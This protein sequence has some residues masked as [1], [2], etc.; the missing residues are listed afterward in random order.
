MPR[1][2][3]FV[4]PFP[5]ETTMRFARALPRLRDVRV[6]AIMQ[7]PPKGDDVQVFDDVV[8]VTDALSARDLIDATQVLASRHGAPH[9]VL[10]ILEAVQVQLAAVRAHFGV[11]GT[12]VRTADLF[13]DKA[14][15]KDALRAAGLPCARH[16][17][18]ASMR[19]AEDFA[20]EVGFPMVLKPPAGMGAK[21]TF[22]V[23]AIDQLRGA[24]DGMR[25][26][27]QK[28]MLAEEFLRGRE[29]S[30]ETIT[31]GGEVRFHS[32]SEYFP[33]PL[34]VL[35][36]PWMQWCCVLPRELTREHDDAREVGVAAIRA[37]GLDDGFTHMEWFR[38]A[39]G[40]IAIG[41]I[42]QRPPGANITR[43]TGLAHDFDPYLAWARS[44]VDGAFDGP[45]E[46]RWS[47]GCAFLRGMGRGR[48]ARLEGVD[49]ANARVR[50]YVEEAKL[51][52]IGAPKSDSY[53]GDGYA[54]VRARDTD[55]VKSAL[56]TIIETVRVHYA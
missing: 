29:H 37:L 22:R 25:V 36:N 6:L 1:N 52:T 26:S 13:R 21:A 43:M 5:L 49:E 11:P 47:V 30:F 16:R 48:V 46:R 50:Q 33:T 40:S 12:D 10:G 15:M 27:A 42:A 7:E 31:T 41:E 3:I 17:L 9:R 28:P 4:A 39:D 35:E 34:E 38:R 23:S 56:K 54:I 53:E 24:I 45:Y 32:V 51:P 2:L 20:R 8:R 44:V 55:T 14:R 19:D 18:L